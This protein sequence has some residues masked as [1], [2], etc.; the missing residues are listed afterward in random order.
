MGGRGRVKVLE[1]GC[2]KPDQAL[3]RSTPAPLGLQFPGDERP[4]CANALSM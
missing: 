4:L 1:L 3:T 2:I